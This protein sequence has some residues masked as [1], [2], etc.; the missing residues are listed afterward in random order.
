[1]LEPGFHAV[2]RG[3][4]ATIVTHL[5]MRRP[6]APRPEA[7]GLT[8]RLRL[9]RAE[10]PGRD[11]YRGLFRR[12][13]QDWLW[14]SRL[15]MSDAALDEVLHDPGV[16]VY[17]LLDDI[18]EVGLLELDFRQDGACELAFFGLVPGHVGGGVGRWLMNRAVELAW[19]HP[20]RRFHVHTCTLDHPAALE[21]YRRSGF[22][23]VRQE[24]E[25]APDPR[26]TGVFP[27]SAAPH[28]PILR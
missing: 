9:R 10:R 2:P 24:V 26:L 21:F 17:G 27:D 12:V 14:F 11:W 13:G 7:E 18:H 19:A 3:H 20:I 28:V 15:A 6:A 23:P 22:T 25:I 8:G 4:V 5:E 16:H 1:M